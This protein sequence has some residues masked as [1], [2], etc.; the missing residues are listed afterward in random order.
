MRIRSKQSG[1]GK[2]SLRPRLSASGRLCDSAL[3]AKGGAACGPRAASK[4]PSVTWN[5]IWLSEPSVHWDSPPLSVSCIPC[6]LISFRNN[7]TTRTLSNQIPA[8]K[9]KEVNLW[10]RQPCMAPADAP[11]PPL[12]R[13]GSRSLRQRWGGGEP[14]T[15]GT[16][17][18][19]CTEAPGLGTGLSLKELRVT[20]LRWPFPSVNRAPGI[21]CEPTSSSWVLF[22]VPESPFSNYWS[23]PRSIVTVAV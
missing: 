1:L 16:C 4:P 3:Q 12:P 13:R 22:S 19:G 18:P 8:Y 15:V 21:V 14:G 2:R 5:L 7:V 20:H 10:G 23:S 17:C 6:C 9:W 11:L